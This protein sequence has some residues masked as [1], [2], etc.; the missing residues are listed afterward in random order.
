MKNRFKVTG[1]TVLVLGLLAVM[2]AAANTIYT[3]S[4]DLT[5][6]PAD[7]DVEID[8]NI[9]I[10]DSGDPY[11]QSADTTL[12][13]LMRGG[14]TN[15]VVRIADQL[16]NGRIVI[17]EPDNSN[18]MTFIVYNESSGSS[19]T[20]NLAY[21]SA[22]GNINRLNIANDFDS[23]SAYTGN[24]VDLGTEVRPWKNVYYEGSLTDT[25]PDAI[26]KEMKATGKTALDFTVTRADE[27]LD[28]S[29]AP[30]SVYKKIDIPIFNE[31]GTQIGLERDRVTQDIGEAAVWNSLR[32]TELIERIDELEARVAALEKG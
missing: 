23:F 28:I 4:G 25:A 17:Y 3:S 11:I 21:I 1:G 20:N 19:A 5:L 10:T 13:F 2:V 12:D 14:T 16:T 22:G 6:D 18:T 30:T 8:G 32:I 27:T 9:K 7:G 29:K 15:K 31:N 26:E 24:S